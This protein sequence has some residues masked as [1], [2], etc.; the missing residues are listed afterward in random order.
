MTSYIDSLNGRAV[1]YLMNAQ[2]AWFLVGYVHVV[3]EDWQMT[4]I[5]AGASSLICYQKNLNVRQASL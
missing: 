2:G 1:L 5:V 4:A 3:N